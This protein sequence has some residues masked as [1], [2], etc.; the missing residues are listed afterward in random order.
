MGASAS[1]ISNANTI[2]FVSQSVTVDKGAVLDL[3]GGGTLA[4]AGFIEG[5]GGS[6]D[7]LSTPLSNSNPANNFSSNG[8]QVFAI[9]PGFQG[10][11]APVAPGEGM[12]PTIGEQITIPAGVPG[13]PA[14]TYTLLP[15][16]Y[17]LLPGGYRVE[18][19]G[20]VSGSSLIAGA[21]AAGS[22]NFIVDGS[23]GIANTGVK[24]PLPIEMILTPGSAVRNDSDFDEEDFTTF[25][26]QQA[27]TLGQTVPFVPDDAGTLLLNYW[28]S[29]PGA[30][31]GAALSFNGT[32]LI[33]PA[34][35]G[36]TGLVEVNTITG[37]TNLEIVAICADTGFYRI[38]HLGTGSG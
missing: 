34:A 2:T 4:G 38:F 7:V 12:A 21:A 19:G 20:K 25:A 16:N 32:A 8:N 24:S 37:G 31:A 9:V 26:V 6:V 15:A 30:D 36:V 10:G 5:E 28:G 27:Q 23:E 1:L 3:S 29:N 17:A 18:L 22:G 13:L 14:G 35:G 33:A 11:Y